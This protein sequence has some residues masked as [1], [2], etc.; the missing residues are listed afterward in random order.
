MKNR[1]HIFGASGSG[2]TTIAKKI[3]ETLNYAHFDTDS[4]YWHPTTPPFTQKRPIE[5]RL[6]M[7]NTDLTTQEKWILSGSLDGWGDPLLPLFE[8]IVFVYVP[9]KARIERLKKRE[10]ERYGNNILPGGSMYQ[11]SQEFIN[12][13][14]GYESGELSGRNLPRHKKWMAQLNHELLR[15]ENHSLEESVVTIL[16]AIKTKSPIPK[17]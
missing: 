8:L 5:T 3:S 6:Q 12:W 7:M 16:T 10:I 17:R 9:Q 13:A 15:I 4:Y 1:I 14:K 11:S 2:T